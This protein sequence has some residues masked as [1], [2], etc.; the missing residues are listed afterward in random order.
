MFGLLEIILIR[1]RAA[2]MVSGKKRSVTFGGI[3][4]NITRIPLQTFK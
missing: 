1:L 2:T 4:W 3:L